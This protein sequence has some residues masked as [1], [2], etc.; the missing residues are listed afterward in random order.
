MLDECDTTMKSWDRCDDGA[1]NHGNG[2]SQPCMSIQ[3]RVP[4]WPG[5]HTPPRH[6][7]GQWCQD[8]NREPPNSR[9]PE[10]RIHRLWKSGNPPSGSHWEGQQLA[11]CLT[12]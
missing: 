8:V 10:L 12:T 5:L 4:S 7:K 1:D 9:C 3:L 2:G 11:I 6:G